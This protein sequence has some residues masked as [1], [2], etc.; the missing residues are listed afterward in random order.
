[1]LKT[2]KRPVRPVVSRENY[3]LQQIEQAFPGGEWVDGAQEEEAEVVEVPGCDPGGSGF[4]S[5]T[6]LS[7]ALIGGPKYNERSVQEYLAALPTDT[8]VY[9]GAG[10]GVE[11][12]LAKAEGLSVQ[13]E[14]VD[15]EP[16]RF[17]KLARKLNVPQVLCVDISSPVVL[18][19]AGERVK[20]ARSWLKTVDGLRNPENRREVVEL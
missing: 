13:V 9:V 1:M 18:V 15:L 20:H 5:H 10:R 8:T 4:E 3:A 12:D 17:G 11:A 16:D 6:P 19:G 2:R 14:V 7:V